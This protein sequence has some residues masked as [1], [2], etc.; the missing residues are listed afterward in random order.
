MPARAA[1]RFMAE[2]NPLFH[3]TVLLA[4]N[5]LQLIVSEK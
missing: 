3:D 4:A 1:T 2:E 5:S